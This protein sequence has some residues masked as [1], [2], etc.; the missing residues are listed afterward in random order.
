MR[1]AHGKQ[2]CDRSFSQNWTDEVFKIGGRYQKKG[3]NL[4]RIGNIKGDEIFTGSFY[5]SEMQRVDKEE[6]SL[7]IVEK[8]LKKRKR[9]GKTEYLCKFQGWSSQYKEFISEENIKTLS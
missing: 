8:I 6:N 5:E 4:Y 3:I 2:I 1:I 7:W 9:K